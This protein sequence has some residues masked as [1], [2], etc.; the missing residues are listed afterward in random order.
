M[1]VCVGGGGGGVC[2]Q[3]ICYHVAIFRDSNKFDMHH[4]PCS[5]KMNFDLLTFRVREGGL[6]AKYLLPYF[7][8]S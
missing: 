8:I 7:C 1:C 3:N 4:D 5:E 2:G 6:R